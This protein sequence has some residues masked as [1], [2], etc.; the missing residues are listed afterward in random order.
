MTQ[1][2]SLEL[3]SK[4]ALERACSDNLLHIYT[5]HLIIVPRSERMGLQYI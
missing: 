2:Y 4:K 5:V 1:Y 3:S